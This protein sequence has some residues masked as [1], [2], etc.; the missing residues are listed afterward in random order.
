MGALWVGRVL[1]TSARREGAQDSRLIELPPSWMPPSWMSP[2]TVPKGK[3]AWLVHGLF[4]IPAGSNMGASAHFSLVR[5]CH[6]ARPDPKWQEMTV[7]PQAW[8]ETTGKWHSWWAHCC[9]RRCSHQMK[10]W[11]R[12]RWTV[13]RLTVIRS[14]FFNLI[15]LVMQ[16]YFESPSSLTFISSWNLVESMLF[17][18]LCPTA[19]LLPTLNPCTPFW[20]T[21]FLEVSQS[22]KYSRGWTR[23]TASLPS[24]VKWLASLGPVFQ[25]KHASAALGF[26]SQRIKEPDTHLGSRGSCPPGWCLSRLCRWLPYQEVQLFL[27]RHLLVQAGS[28]GRV[29]QSWI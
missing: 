25:Q 1:C 19:S 9:K 21:V 22:L 13:G 7:S 24:L 26:T 18:A 5:A 15:H 2:V 10:L 28:P 12:S 11:E 20:R 8:K 27:Q 4:L 6:M 23:I 29:L 3:T 17:P 16:R 14:V